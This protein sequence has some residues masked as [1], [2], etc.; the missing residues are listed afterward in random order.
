MYKIPLFFLL[1]FF[2]AATNAQELKARVS[3]ISNRVNNTVD[4]QTFTTL[5]K[6]LNNFVNNTKWSSDTYVTNEKIDCSFLLNLQS[7]DE[8]NVYKASLII[9]SGRPVFNSSY[10]SPV[11]NY[12]D[13]DFT[14]K[15]VEFQQLDF[16]DARVSGRSTGF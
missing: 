2:S 12:Q 13:N 16:N 4:K 15:Y 9:Q 8:A 1:C 3:V 11:I 14:F 5:E 10:I 6:A 7:T